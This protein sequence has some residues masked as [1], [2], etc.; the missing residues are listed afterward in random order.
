VLSLLT[1]RFFA[2]GV[3]IFALLG[4]F[5]VPLGEH[6]GFQHARAIASSPQAEQFYDDLTG[7]VRRAADQAV[8]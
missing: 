8:R 1:K 5:G 2:L 7:A 3:S 4:F 6:T